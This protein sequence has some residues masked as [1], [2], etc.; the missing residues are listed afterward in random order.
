MSDEMKCPYCAE[1]IKAEAVKCRFCGSDLNTPQP[2]RMDSANAGAFQPKVAACSSC[3]VA[4]VAVEKARAVSI[5]GLLSVI[6]VI[7]GVI[8]LAFNVV[9]GI[10]IIILGLIIGAVGRG[11]K[12]VMVCPKCGQQ[13]ATL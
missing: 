5:G 11:K 6:V 8:A 12:I 4:L 2:Q 3:N 9:V 13:R 1:T 7:V 10:L